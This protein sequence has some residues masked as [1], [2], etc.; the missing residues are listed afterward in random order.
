MVTAGSFK[1]IREGKAKWKFGKAKVY[2]TEPF[3]ILGRINNTYVCW[4]N[5]R[6]IEGRNRVHCDFKL[7]MQSLGDISKYKFETLGLKEISDL[8]KFQFENRVQIDLYHNLSGNSQNKHNG[9][10]MPD[11]FDTKFPRF[12]LTVDKWPHPSRCVWMLSGVVSN[13]NCSTPKCNFMAQQLCDL[14]KHES[15][16]TGETKIQSRCITYG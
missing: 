7:F 9:C 6:Q 1:A 12:S 5:P 2:L 11:H 14:I 8:D 3:C 4:V 15:K 16:C 10:G 13:R